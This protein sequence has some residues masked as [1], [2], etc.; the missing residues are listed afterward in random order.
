MKSAKQDDLISQ[1]NP[2]NP[3]DPYEE[4]R[5]Q[6][7]NGWKQ[8]FI[9]NPEALEEEL[10][11]GLLNDANG[12]P[13]LSEHSNSLP[14]SAGHP[15]GA[16]ANGAQASVVQTNG[17]PARRAILHW[18]EIPDPLALPAQKIEWVLDGIIPCASVTLIAGEP[19]SYKSWLAL[20]LV[21]AVT[22]V[23]AKDCIATR[24]SRNTD[25]SGVNSRNSDASDDSY[26]EGNRSNTDAAGVVSSPEGTRSNTGASGGIR[27]NTYT[28]RDTF[29]GRKCLPMD[30]LYLDREN[31]L[32]VVR[33]RMAILG[34][35]SLEHARYWGGWLHDAPPGIIKL[36][37]FKSR[38]SEEFSMTVRPELRDRGD[39]VVTET[40]DSV[41]NP[42]IDPGPTVAEVLWEAIR[43]RPGQT[44]SELLVGSGLSKGKVLPVLEDLDGK[45]W[46]S[47]R[48]K[49]NARL[50]FPLNRL[51][52]SEFDLET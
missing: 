18:D 11:Q 12:A 14:G 2:F 22:S 24:V 50:F 26:G 8:Y 19:G 36:D 42:E 33:E 44:Q 47:E 29:L 6:R 10:K 25:G 20:C 9:E 21:R 3:R 4:L 17:T 35:N 49:N 38:F 51:N 52:Q 41:V 40:K 46:R 45:M 34:I 7:A 48:I 5:A 31:P 37:C 27:R 43:A 13:S 28:R 15:N 1:C 30:A 32:S 23:A 39:F 16:P